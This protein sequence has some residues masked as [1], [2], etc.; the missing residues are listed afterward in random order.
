MTRADG[1]GP[2][3]YFGKIPARSDFIKAT[4]DIALMGVLDDWLA[5]VMS[6]L[7]SDPRWKSHYDGLAPFHF[8]FVGPRRRH[9]IGG[10]VVASRDQSGRR[11]PFLMMGRFAPGD[12]AAFVARCPLALDPLWS[13]LGQI[14]PKVLAESEPACHLHDISATV[15]G[16]DPDCDAVLARFLGG[17]SVGALGALL[18]RSD[19]RELILALGLLLQPVRDRDQVE[20]DKSLVLPLPETPGARH[21]VA[22]FWLELIAPLLYRANVD[23]ALFVTRLREQPV[24]VVGLCG[25]ATDTLHA[26]IDPRAA[27]AQQVTLDDT[28][29]VDGQLG[30]QVALRELASHLAQPQLPLTLAREL[31]LQTFLGASS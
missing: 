9:A 19:T 3:A 18:G 13:F 12:P 30:A 5:Q 6:R 11:Y 23:L 22:A 4:Q 27:C 16:L 8:A 2:I 14:A 21:P 31:F 28:G 15:I 25:R 10:H 1:A 26:I 7:L 29:W 17:A 24:L 20:L